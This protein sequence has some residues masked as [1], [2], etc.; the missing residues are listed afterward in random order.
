MHEVKYEVNGNGLSPVVGN[1]LLPEGQVRDP[2]HDI[3]DNNDGRM[4]THDSTE[5]C[6]RQVG[7]LRRV[8]LA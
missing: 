4:P 1:H 7:E 8:C 3:G 5:V 2:P 6:V